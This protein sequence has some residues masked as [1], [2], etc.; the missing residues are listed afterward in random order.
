M[1]F[2]AI[3]IEQVTEIRLCRILQTVFKVCVNK[4]VL[5]V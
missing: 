2:E 1:P 5:P 4:L 3:Y